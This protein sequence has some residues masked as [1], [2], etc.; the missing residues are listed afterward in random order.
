ME[1]TQ[2]QTKLSFVSKRKKE[3]LEAGKQRKYLWLENKKKDNHIV[4][5][6]IC[7]RLNLSFLLCISE[8]HWNHCFPHYLNLR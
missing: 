4:N 1:I 5:D 6:V 7:L 8:R 3:Q 2:L